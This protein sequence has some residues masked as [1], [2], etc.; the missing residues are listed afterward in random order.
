MF[1]IDSGQ[2]NRGQPLG[3]QIFKL[4]NEVVN[5]KNIKT[6]INYLSNAIQGKERADSKETYDAKVASA[7][8]EH[9][10]KWSETVVIID[11]FEKM[12]AVCIP[13]DSI[14][15]YQDIIMVR[16]PNRDL[17]KLNNNETSS[18]LQCL[19]Q[20]SIDARLL[21]RHK[22]LQF[23]LRVICDDTARECFRHKEYKFACF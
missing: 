2:I 7:L 6:I 12:K 23:F 20:N 15:E 14:P 21:H 10:L 1:F 13:L 19:Q 11:E 18:Q 22:F 16:V 9:L 3:K 5:L 4:T 8:L 17:K